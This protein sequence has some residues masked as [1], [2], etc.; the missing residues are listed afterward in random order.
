MTTSSLPQG[1]SVPAEHGDPRD[2]VR[3]FRR[4]LGQYATGVTV[5]TTSHLGER[6]GM[7]A[8]SFAAVSLD[9]PLIVW[10]IRKESR[11]RD[12]FTESGHFAVNVLAGGQTDV[13]GLFAR[14]HDGQMS[15]VEWVE[16]DL[17]DPLLAGAVAQFQCVT[18]SVVE[19]G[20]HLMILGRVQRFARFDG[21]PLC[22]ALGQ[23]GT[24]RR[25]PELGTGDAHIE[26]EADPAGETSLFMSLLKAADHHMSALFDEHRTAVGVTV[27]TGRVL[28]RLA[29]G[30]RSVQTLEDEAFIGENAAQDALAQLCAAGHVRQEQGGLWALTESGRE[31]RAALRR[32]AETFTAEQLDGIDP[33]DL[34]AAERVLATLLRRPA[35]RS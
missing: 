23:Y 3:A 21:P 28:N 10:S 18:E 13:S 12:A 4:A 5:I 7:T 14:A 30:A 1:L 24:F 27:A 19:A 8:N 32:S 6:I 22:F 26:A 29:L 25:H 2:D 9:P 11:S 33:V 31:L 34:Q 15:T 35:V 20:D 17:G 16:G